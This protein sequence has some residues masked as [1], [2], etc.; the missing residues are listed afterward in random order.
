MRSYIMKCTVLF[1]LML[2]T[3]GCTTMGNF[4]PP[5]TSKVEI[6]MTKEQVKALWGKPN[7]VWYPNRP[8][9]EYEKA[10][11]PNP[12]RLK[13]HDDE[14][15]PDE[16]WYYAPSFFNIFPTKGWDMLF[17]NGVVVKILHIKD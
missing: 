17:K 12:P 10:L 11:F 16:V 15:N 5:K 14:T 7:T 3:L 8:L 9:G 1:V 4:A 13:Y 6:G 2:I